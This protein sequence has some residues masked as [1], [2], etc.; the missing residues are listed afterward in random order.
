MIL[1]YLSASL[2]YFQLYLNYYYYL[3]ILN[4]NIGFK[5]IIV[6]MASLLIL[7]V[8]SKGKTYEDVEDLMKK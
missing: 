1:N 6:S 8:H 5:L 3:N 2:L 4:M 7:Q